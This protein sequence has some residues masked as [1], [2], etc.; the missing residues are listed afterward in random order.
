MT[1]LTLPTSVEHFPLGK[2]SLGLRITL[3]FGVIVRHFHP[4]DRGRARVPGY[5]AKLRR[6]CTVF[7]LKG[8]APNQPLGEQS[9]LRS[10][11]LSS[12]PAD[13]RGTVTTEFRGT[14]LS[15][16]SWAMG[17]VASRFK[18][19][20]GMPRHSILLF[21]RSELV[22][23]S[24]AAGFGNG[25]HFHR[26]GDSRLSDTKA[27]RRRNPSGIEGPSG[28]TARTFCRAQ[29]VHGGE[30]LCSLVPSVLIYPKTQRWDEIANLQS[31]NASIVES[32]QFDF[33]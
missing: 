3:T 16:I 33:G 25:Q 24:N 20:L 1:T 26:R 5:K 28:K 6:L 18:Y 32:G 14:V 2:F 17:I 4:G 11:K 13:S 23:G 15:I 29:I 30:L 21:A 19:R 7:R 8:G 9:S 31:E 12:C 22:S 27:R 10:Q